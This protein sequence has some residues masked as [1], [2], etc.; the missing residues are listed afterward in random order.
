MLKKLK[1]LLKS[2][3]GSLLALAF[4]ALI[5]SGLLYFSFSVSRWWLIVFLALSFYFY[6]Q[7]LLNSRR[8]LVLFLIVVSLSLISHIS[9]ISPISPIGLISLFLGFLFF[10]LLGIKDLIFVHRQQFSYFLNSLLFLA[11]FVYFFA[12][13]SGSGYFVF[14]YLAAFSAVF[15]LLLG[16][17]SPIRLISPISPIGPIKLIAAGLS[18]SSVQ[19][20]WAISLLPFNFLN[21]ASLALLA[22]LILEDFAVHRLSGTISRRVVLRNTTLFLILSLVIFAATKW[23]P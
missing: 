15:L 7:S 19:I 12:A 10:L 14:K 18:F 2:H 1:S 4:K 16:P 3:K 5:L 11:V 22:V 21:S 17:I 13:N 9:P 6:F 23:S 20:L 8:F